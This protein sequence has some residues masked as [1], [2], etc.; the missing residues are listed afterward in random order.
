[1][2]EGDAKYLGVRHNLFP[3]TYSLAKCMQDI[4]IEGDF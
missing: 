2:H 3:L 1:M 4:T